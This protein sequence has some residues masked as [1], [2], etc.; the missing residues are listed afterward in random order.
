L[1]YVAV[2]QAYRGKGIGR[3]VVQVLLE[4]VEDPLFATT[5]SAAMGKILSEY[6]FTKSGKSWSGTAGR[7][8]L[9]KRKRIE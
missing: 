8:T 9:W 7:L 1:G 2:R 6:G 3:D 5:A 4:G